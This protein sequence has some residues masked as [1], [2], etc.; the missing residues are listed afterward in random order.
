VTSSSLSARGIQV[1]CFPL[2]AF[3]AEAP[4]I[5]TPDS[6]SRDLQYSNGFCHASKMRKSF[7]TVLIP[8]LSSLLATGASKR[9]QVAITPTAATVPSAGSQQFSASVS[10]T[11]N[12]AVTWSASAG[13]VSSNGSF[14]APAVTQNTIVYVKA[15]SIVD[16]RKAATASVTVTAA[17]MPTTQ[18]I[19]DLGWNN[20]SSANISGYNVYR[21]TNSSGP[22]G[23]INSVGLVASTLYTDAS[24]KSGQTYYYVVTAVDSSGAESG[25][26]NVSQAVVLSP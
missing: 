13:T 18:H 7:L 10:G 17:S 11:S 12:Q 25:Y 8:L 15:T 22:Y 20:A 9:V 3:P 2:L 4:S 19:V 5:R 1:I 23:K 14:I 26:S 21:G 24:V 6:P 16:L